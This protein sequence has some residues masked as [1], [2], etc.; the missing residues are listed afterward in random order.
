[1]MIYVLLECVSEPL[2]HLIKKKYIISAIT[3]ITL[4]RGS[5]DLPSPPTELFLV[6]EKSFPVLVLFK[7]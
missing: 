6:P 4:I 5:D 3:A 2:I 1:M 7:P